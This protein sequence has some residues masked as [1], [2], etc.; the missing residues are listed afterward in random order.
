[1]D[2]MIVPTDRKTRVAVQ[3]TYV[4]QALEAL[5]RAIVLE[6]NDDVRGELRDAAT[7]LTDRKRRLD[8]EYAEIRQ[9]EASVASA[10]LEG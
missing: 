7:T 10:A 3:G 1:M 8:Q 4:R 2:D 9:A 5:R 6:D